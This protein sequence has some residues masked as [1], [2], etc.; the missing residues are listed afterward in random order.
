MHELGHTLGLH[1]GGGDDTN[2]K[3]NY[4]SIMSYAFQTLAADPKRPLT[5]SLKELPE[6][7]EAT[8]DETKGIQGPA[9]RFVVFGVGRTGFPPSPLPRADQPIDWNGD[10]DATD[11][12]ASPGAMD[13]DP[14]P[15]FIQI[16][17][18]PGDVRTLCKSVSAKQPLKGHDDWSNLLYNFR[19]SPD[20][21][22]GIRFNL[23]DEEITAEQVLGL[24]RTVD[25]DGD[26]VVNA[27]DNCPG[28]ANPG[29]EDSDGDGI[30]D[31]C[32][33]G[34]PAPGRQRPGDS[35]Q[36]GTLDLSDGIHLLGFLFQGT[37]TR[38]PCGDGTLGE[39]GNVSLL[40]S[41]GDGSVD[42]SD[43]V[44]IFGYLFGGSGPPDL[45]TSC[46]PIDGCP[47]LPGGCGP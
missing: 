39:P 46:V 22:D 1:H 44:R 42:L 11:T 3:P 38:L 4:L 13:P 9:D 5:Y 8:L 15:R 20:Y 25:F 32:D 16:E 14:D 28:E 24:A 31:A 34:G 33:T 23:P 43:A 27:M 12:D 35:N 7:W 2:C 30:G 19:L 18:A 21:A 29:Q 40:D 41:N 10:G 37:V 17:V 47:D 26:G 6:L 36:D 45:G